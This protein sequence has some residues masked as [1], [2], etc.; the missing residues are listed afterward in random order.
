[1]ET[2]DAFD[3][4][5]KSYQGTG[6]LLSS[7]E[8]LVFA[9]LDASKLSDEQR[10]FLRLSEAKNQRE[11]VLQEETLEDA[12][13]ARQELQDA[14]Q[15]LEVAKRRV[16]DELVEERVYRLQAQ[17]QESTSTLSLVVSLSVPTIIILCVVLI[18]F[19]DSPEKSAL[20]EKIGLMAATALGFI[21]NNLFQQQRNGRSN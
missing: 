15:E 5:F 6:T 4:R 21:I 7:D 14:N 1:M 19:S 16:E 9:S 13:R 11:L 18:F 20:I 2:N 10:E 3:H 17:K 8:C 12:E